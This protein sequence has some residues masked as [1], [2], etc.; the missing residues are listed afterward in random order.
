VSRR[1]RLVL[2]VLC[3]NKINSE[4]ALGNYTVVPDLS[5]LVVVA[6][7]LCIAASNRLIDPRKSF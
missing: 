7:F 2:C 1:S 3:L 4:N 6:S 5:V